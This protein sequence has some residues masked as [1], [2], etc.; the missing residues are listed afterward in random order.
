MGMGSRE[1]PTIPAPLAQT[2]TCRTIMK[3][4]IEGS[5]TLTGEHDQHDKIGENPKKLTY[6]ESKREEWVELQY[7][8]QPCEKSL[9]NGIKEKELLGNF[10]MEIPE[11]KFR[12]SN[13]SMPLKGVRKRS[14]GIPLEIRKSRSK[15][16]SM[17]N[18]QKQHVI[19]RYDINR[20]APSR[21]MVLR[22]SIQ[23]QHVIQRYEINRPAP[24][25]VMVLRC[26]IQKRHVIQRYEINRPAP[27]RVM[28]LRCSIQKQHLIQSYEIDRPAPSRGDGPPM[29]LPGVTCDIRA[30][31][32]KCSGEADMSKDTSGPESP[33]E[34]RRS[35]YVKGQTRSG[36]I[37]PVLAQQ[38]QETVLG[39]EGANLGT[40]QP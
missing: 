13:R 8:K 1:G 17:L 11:Q 21:V 14:S 26:N 31:L 3:E 32:D 6:N 19:Q 5:R 30:E 29:E 23:K 9:I 7:A 34:L 39:S 37:S 33:E 12:S 20:P 4:N 35:W 28:V 18:I 15:T 36:V 40:R 16:Y 10:Y 38:Y 2:N 25:R 27:S 22:C 24:S